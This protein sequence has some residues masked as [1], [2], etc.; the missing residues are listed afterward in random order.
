MISEI[1]AIAATIYCLLPRM[2]VCA[3]VKGSNEILARNVPGPISLASRCGGLAIVCIM[4]RS[5]VNYFNVCFVAR[6]VA[7]STGN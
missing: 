3:A 4:Q 1:W 5:Q 7:G 6:S 2:I